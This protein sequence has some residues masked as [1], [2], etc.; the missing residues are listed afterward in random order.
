[1]EAE[2]N[3]LGGIGWRQGE[4]ERKFGCSPQPAHA[5]DGEARVEPMTD[6]R[7]EN[8]KAKRQTY[9]AAV[10]EKHGA[11]VRQVDKDT[12]VQNLSTMFSEGEPFVVA[13]AESGFVRHIR[14]FA[15][16][17]D[18]FVRQLKPRQDEFSTSYKFITETGI[19]TSA[20]PS[21]SVDKACQL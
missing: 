10:R 16:V 9:R 3:K 1:M 2:A 5:T 14:K 20:V 21:A 15:D 6:F 4:S 18:G 19:R 13:V 17:K 8:H 7:A 11:H 12:S